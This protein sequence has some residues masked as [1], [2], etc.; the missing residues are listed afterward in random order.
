M[1]ERFSNSRVSYYHKRLY[2]R[3]CLSICIHTSSPINLYFLNPN[4]TCFI[5][6]DWERTII[7][8]PGHIIHRGQ[9]RT[10]NLDRECT[11]KEVNQ[12]CHGRAITLETSSRHPVL[13]THLHKPRQDQVPVFLFNGNRSIPS[14][15]LPSR[16]NRELQHRSKTRP[17]TPIPTQTL[18]SWMRVS[19]S[20]QPQSQCICQNNWR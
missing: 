19:R 10:I 13:H 6:M 18:L 12:T 11:V 1:R 17:N 20:N 5:H 7:M 8:Y 3:P 9:E 14:Q 2:R 15:K 16:R 4:P